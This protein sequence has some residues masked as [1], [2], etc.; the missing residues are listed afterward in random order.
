MEEVE[1]S[2]FHKNENAITL[3]RLLTEIVLD[4]G[5]VLLFFVLGCAIL[6]TDSMGFLILYI[7]FWISFY[8]FTLW[9]LM[10]KIS[11]QLMLFWIFLSSK[12]YKQKIKSASSQSEEHSPK[13]IILKSKIKADLDWKLW[14]LRNVVALLMISGSYVLSD[15]AI[16]SSPTPLNGRIIYFFFVVPSVVILI[17]NCFL[18]NTLFGIKKEASMSHI[19]RD[20][21]SSHHDQAP[22]SSGPRDWPF[23]KDSEASQQLTLIL[24][25]IQLPA[26]AQELPKRIIMLRVAIDTLFSGK[27]SSTWEALLQET[28]GNYLIQD[29]S[30]RTKNLENAI[31]A[32]ERALQCYTRNKPNRWAAV[33]ANLAAI[34]LER[35][36]DDRAQNIEKSIL[37]SK[38][39]LEV[40]TREAMPVEWARTVT[41]LALAY[42]KR[43]QGDHIQNIEDAISAYG[44][45]LQVI[46]RA[47]MP[48]EWAT[49]M[50][51]LGTAYR[52]RILG[53]QTQNIEKAISS[54]ESALEIRKQEAMP[55]DWAMVKINLGNAYS[56]RTKGNRS[57]N[58]EYAISCYKQALQIIT[59]QVLPFEWATSMHNLGSTYIMRIQGDRSQ[60]IEDA[61]SAFKQALKVR[62]HST[63]PVEWAESM[64]NLA[65]A[66]IVRIQGDRSQN[67]EDAISAFKQALKVRNRSTMPIEWAES[68]VGLASAYQ[69]DPQGDEIQRIENSITIWKQVLEVLT[70][71]IHPQHCRNAA[72]SLGNLYADQ[73]R[74]EEA[75]SA[76]TTALMTADYLYESS[77]SKDSQISEISK[78]RDLYRRAAFAYAKVGDLEVAVATLE[79]NR[80]QSLR[81]ALQ[82]DRVDLEGIRRVNPGLVE[83]YQS[84]INAIRKSESAERHTRLNSVRAQDTAESLVLGL[85]T[86]NDKH[87]REDLKQL[88]DQNLQP[89]ERESS[90]AD[91]L[92]QITIQ[93]RQDLR[94]C[95][96][97]IRQISGYES[98]LAAPTFTDIMSVVSDEQPLAYLLH[99]PN[100]NLALILTVHGITPLW[101][102]DLDGQSFENWL[103]TNLF[104]LYSQYSNN[105]QDWLNC[106]DDLTQQVWD[107]A[108]GSLVDY[109]K[110]N[111]FQRVTLIP[112]GYLGFLPLHASWTTDYVHSSDRRYACDDIQ[113]TYA[114]NALSL[115]AA[116]TVAQRVPANTL[117]AINEPLPS[118]GRPLPN[119]G[120]EI[121]KAISK[122]P[123]KGNWKLLQHEEAFHQAILDT[124]PTCNVAHFSCHGYADLQSPL[125]SGL[126]IAYNQFLR[127]RDFLDLNLKGLRLAILSACE[128]GIS[129]AE[130]PDEAVSLPTGLLQA[131]AAGVVSSLWSVSDLSTMLLISRFY[132]LWR[133]HDPTIQPL[134]PPAALR[135]AQ[136]WLR[137]S[138]GP[139]LVPYLQ[140][141]HPELAAR[142]EQAPGK[143]PFAHPYYWAAF[144]YTGV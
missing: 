24:K 18:I 17:G 79:K 126:Q 2:N 57:Q 83:R 112:T 100:G 50:M 75:K 25:I 82:Q 40:Y 66:Y 34:Y 120:L 111:N 78:N 94:A 93:A 80:A 30:S 110:S 45:G 86:A 95:V 10:A 44:Q 65:N 48:I 55:L 16:N 81:E 117:L 122:F 135:Q 21:S 58:L 32:F 106:I 139:D 123:G 19:D 130:L 37:A 119:A 9:N 107:R 13:K 71:E 5:K 4:L 73:A 36:R 102:D 1:M 41:N 46:T 85:L 132:E 53:D 92:V 22:R 67:I 31:I 26:T 15:F 3:E 39:A 23:P 103:Q 118:K 104:N 98:F 8:F 47:A 74:W 6:T 115:Q 59:P 62:N 76:Y 116:R 33:Q 142:L 38:Q 108:I 129:G 88:I 136:L 131:G 14:I 56:S 63:M 127:L 60:N 97:E 61:I 20:N 114:P 124:L 89:K 54:F 134:E 99:T 96:A 87:N 43:I 143:R 105:R 29:P 27:P 91:K 12:S 141:S 138:T 133:P 101:L 7:L 77:L 109:F 69:M 42:S 72:Y 52:K 137:D 11:L 51:N 49:T 64:T 125:N 68:M 113:F 84:A 70:P 140:T 144:T 35:N 28:L 128:T 121:A 90:E